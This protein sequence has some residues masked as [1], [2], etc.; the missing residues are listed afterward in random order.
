M[1]PPRLADYIAGIER[2]ALAAHAAR[3]PWDLP[4]RAR[5]IVAAMLADLDPSFE[6]ADEVAC[7][8]TA[9]IEHGAIVK[10]PAIIG[11]GCL[12]AAGSYLRDG[13][14]L[15]ADCVLGP[16]AEIKS[17]F[18]FRGTRLAHLNFVGDSILGADVNLEAGAVIANRRNELADPSI[19][20]RLGPVVIETGVER[21]GA[22]VGDRSRIGANAV[23][24][25]GALLAPGSIV[26]RLG[27][28]DQ[29][30]P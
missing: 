22:V 30:A 12:L 16:H 17:S 24:A 10:G 25:P 26:P 1:L 13:V 3:P 2:S 4:A 28:V 11:P 14:W 20:I 9:R 8:P 15:E 29:G 19:R 6:I 18:V 5:E 7:H 23:V 27:L 21:F